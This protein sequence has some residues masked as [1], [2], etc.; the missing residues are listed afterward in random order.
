MKRLS[1]FV[2]SIALLLSIQARAGMCE[3]Q[4]NSEL[5][6]YKQTASLYDRV[7]DGSGPEKNRQA[8]YIDCKHSEGFKEK[9][10]DP[11]AAKIVCEHRPTDWGCDRFLKHLRDASSGD[12]P[13]EED[14]E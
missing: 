3:D 5:G 4:H 2:A 11:D 9:M 10:A 6:K 14:Q 12:L 13:V 7:V 8:V 1:L